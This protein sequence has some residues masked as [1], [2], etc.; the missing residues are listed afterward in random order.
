MSLSRTWFLAMTF[1]GA[2]PLA[3]QPQTATA[4]NQTM[5]TNPNATNP[6][7]ITPEPK[8]HPKLTKAHTETTTTTTTT[9][10]TST[11]ARTTHHHRMATRYGGHRG[12][13]FADSTRLAA[14]LAD[15]QGKATISAA[16]WKTVA[17]EANVL[18]NRIYGNSSGSSM[19]HKPAREL[20]M[21]VRE[22]RAAALKGDAGGATSHAAQ[23]L[24]YAYQLIDWSAP[25]GMA[26]KHM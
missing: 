1:V 22:M 16:G 14:L 6:T 23:A 8:H 19:A 12:H 21:H 18:A 17:N 4:A 26:N 2:L 11:E 24:P 13:V 3:A 25:D 9:T 7:A 5:G 10:T 20:R 15:T